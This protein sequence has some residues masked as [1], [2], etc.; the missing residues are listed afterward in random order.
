MT[1]QV[2]FLTT[3][4]ISLLSFLPFDTVAED[5]F[6]DSLH[7][8]ERQLVTYAAIDNASIYPA[9]AAPTVTGLVTRISFPLFLAVFLI[10]TAFI[11]YAWRIRST[12]I[13]GLS[14]GTE[15]KE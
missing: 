8:E 2:T 10:S 1:M 14:S 4:L 15:S 6:P 5:S 13:T 9:T 7:L 12:F 3:A 11:G